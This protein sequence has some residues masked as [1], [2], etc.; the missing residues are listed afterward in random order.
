MSQLVRWEG[1]D[2]TQSAHCAVLREKGG[3]CPWTIA[4]LHI[5]LNVLDFNVDR[6]RTRRDQWAWWEWANPTDIRFPEIWLWEA[7][8]DLK[9]IDPDGL[10]IK[11]ASLTM[12]N[13]KNMKTWKYL[14]KTFKYGSRRRCLVSLNWL[15]FIIIMYRCPW[16]QCSGKLN[17]KD[18]EDTINCRQI[19]MKIIFKSRTNAWCA[20]A[21]HHNPVVS[22][23]HYLISHWLA[24]M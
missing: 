18:T 17:G 16:W 15:I 1:K 14:K 24:M 22:Y 4:H 19:L 10:A 2:T 12:G 20:L 11:I 23:W 9:N 13:L 3:K 8:F 5:T 21:A 7:Q 6:S